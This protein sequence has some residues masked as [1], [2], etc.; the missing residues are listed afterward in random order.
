MQYIISKSKS[1]KSLWDEGMILDI[2]LLNVMCLT[3][4]GNVNRS[5]MKKEK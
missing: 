1:A 4:N 2:L 3:E 5:M